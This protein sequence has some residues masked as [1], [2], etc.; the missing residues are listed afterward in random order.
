MKKR[1]LIIGGTGYLGQSFFDYINDNK[2]KNIRL[3]E[4]VIISRKRKRIKSNIKISYIVKI[5]QMLKKF[6]LQII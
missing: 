5:L 1:L 2:L 3:S 4:I 6:H